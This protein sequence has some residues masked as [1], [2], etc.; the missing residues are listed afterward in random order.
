MK[1]VFAAV[2]AAFVV[3]ALFLIKL[4]LPAPLKIGATYMNLNNPYFINLNDTIRQQVEGRGDILIARDPA[5]DHSRQNEIVYEFL[6]EGVD[7]VIIQP[8]DAR[9][10]QPAIDACYEEG[11]PVVVVDSQI[12]DNSKVL[13]EVV[14]DNYKAGRLIAE[15]MNEKYSGGDV[16]LIYQNN[17]QSSS[18][19][20]Q[21]FLDHVRE[22]FRIVKTINDVEGLEA[23]MER[24]DNCLAEGL[25]FDMVVCGNDPTALGALAALQNAELDEQTEIYGVDGSPD[26]KMMIA[27]GYLN[28]TSVQY[29]S[30][31]GRS[32]VENLYAYLDG[33][34][35]EK[36]ITV[37]VTFLN[38]ENVKDY[39]VIG[40]Q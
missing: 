40:W 22:D 27:R 17:T 14:S 16:L 10:V 6:E 5:L 26:A 12:Y 7:V 33:K 38:E 2:I 30:E 28:G 20:A 35:Y 15:D 29:P 37:D 24:V 23:S 31:I 13:F 19:R 9:K 34:L 8:L 4:E 11:V 39:N 32:C 21:G 25:E 3:L 36:E 18:D 1:K